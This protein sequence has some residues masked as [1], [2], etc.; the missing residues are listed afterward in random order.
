MARGIPLRTDYDS[1]ALWALARSTDDAKQARR[2]L[3]LSLIYDGGLRL[4]QKIGHLFKVY[5]TI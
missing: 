5:S 2:F 1:D 4:S 3:A